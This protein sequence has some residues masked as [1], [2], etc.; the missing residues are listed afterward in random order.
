VFRDNPY[1]GYLREPKR[2]DFVFRRDGVSHSIEALHSERIFDA[3]VALPG[4]EAACSNHAGVLTELEIAPHRGTAAP[5][6]LAWAVG[7]AQRLLAKGKAAAELRRQEMRALSGVGLASA[8]AA[9]VGDRSCKTSRRRFLRWSLRGAAVAALTPTV[10]YSML[11]EVF[12]P[13]EIDGFKDAQM[14]LAKLAGL[15]PVGGLASSQEPP[16]SSS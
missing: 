9:T 1:R 4:R 8:L 6:P 14:Q 16:G 11:S 7:E 5:A 13:T 15:G 12:V 10:G 2:I 3:P